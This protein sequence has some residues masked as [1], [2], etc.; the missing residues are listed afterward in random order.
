VP[1]A[2]ERLIPSWLP[3]T[4]R[5]WARFSGVW[6]LTSGALLLRPETKRVGGYAA[7]ATMVAVFP[8]NIKMAFDAGRPRDLASLGAWL[9]LPLQIPLV[10]WGVRQ[11]KG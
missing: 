3:G 8:G 11:T 5:F 4:P 2:F 6:E 1:K 9:R 7:T 10:A